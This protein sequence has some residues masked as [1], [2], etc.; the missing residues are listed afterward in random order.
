MSMDWCPTNLKIPRGN[1]YSCKVIH[2]VVLSLLLQCAYHLD[3]PRCQEQ[4]A[5]RFRQMYKIAL[6]WERLLSIY[7]QTQYHNLKTPDSKRCCW[8]KLISINFLSSLPMCL[9]LLWAY[10]LRRNENIYYL[11]FCSCQRGCE[12]VDC[13]GRAGSSV[14]QAKDTSMQDP[15]YLQATALVSSQ[16]DL[17]N[18]DQL[19]ISI[20]SNLDQNTS[21]D[22]SENI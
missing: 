15:A 12:S 11:T 5:Y 3:S 14:L 16:A 18:L 10:S 19:Q 7:L 22:A 13:L 4:N 9:P 17:K 8:S 1:S 21:G 2:F 6:L 20:C